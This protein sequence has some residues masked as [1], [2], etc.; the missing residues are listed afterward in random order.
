LV[1]LFVVRRFIACLGIR[2]FG[3]TRNELRYYERKLG[4]NNGI[5]NFKM[6]RV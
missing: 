3:G 6:K 2:G 4:Y 1:L 5:V